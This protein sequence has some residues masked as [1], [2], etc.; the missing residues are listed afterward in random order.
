MTGQLKM[1]KVHPKILERILRVSLDKLTDGQ[2]LRITKY[3][4]MLIRRSRG[5]RPKTQDVI[6]VL[7]WILPDFP[8]LRALLRQKVKN[9]RERR[10]PKREQIATEKKSESENRSTVTSV[11][12][13]QS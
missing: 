2:Q 3:I 13:S 12:N 5:R 6:E 11:K 8:P 7:S 10:K 9:R 1:N 4:L